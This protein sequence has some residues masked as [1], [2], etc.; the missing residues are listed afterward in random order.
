LANPLFAGFVRPEMNNFFPPT[1]PAGITVG[2]LIPNLVA[3]SNQPGQLR[4]LPRWT[5]RKNPNLKP[6][7]FAPSK[8][9]EASATA[10]FSDYK[11]KPCPP[12]WPAMGSRD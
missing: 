6:P 3:A 9:P 1:A 8:A 4:E 2:R 11:G 5:C 12:G 7:R 10:H